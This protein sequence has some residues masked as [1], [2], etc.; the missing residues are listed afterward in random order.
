MGIGHGPLVAFLVCGGMMTT[1]TN[2]QQVY[3]FASATACVFGTGDGTGGSEVSLGTAGSEAACV[4]MVM[5]TH[6][7][8]NGAT[9][10]GD[11]TSPGAC[12][13]EMGMTGR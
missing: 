4:A 12:Y 7:A 9:F 1:P 11:A 10:N 13:A 8:A 3:P 2:A 6:P 5:A